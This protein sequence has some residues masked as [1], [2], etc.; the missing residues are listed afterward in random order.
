MRISTEAVRAVFK[1]ITYIEI[2]FGV[3]EATTAVGH[4]ASP[5]SLIQAAV[6]P[7]AIAFAVR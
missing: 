5:V 1:P 7:D 3:D 6:G 2:A 4:A